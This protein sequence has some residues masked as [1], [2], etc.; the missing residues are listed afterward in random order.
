MG[1]IGGS[2][3]GENNKEIINYFIIQSYKV[4]N[5]GCNS[6]HHDILIIIRNVSRNDSYKGGKRNFLKPQYN[7]RR[8]VLK[9]KA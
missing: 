3:D 8:R 6:S 7:D 1:L 5:G 4:N 2:S 9:K